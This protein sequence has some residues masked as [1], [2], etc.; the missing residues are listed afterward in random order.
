[1]E[2]LFNLL[3]N[4]LVIVLGLSFGSFLNVLIYRLPKEQSIVFPASYCPRCNKSIK[5][6]HNIPILSFILL[7]GKSNCCKT[8]ISLRYPLVEFISLS[9]WVWSFSNLELNNQ[10]IFL[11]MSS[12]LV[13]ILFTDYNEYYIPLELNIIMLL[14]CLIN[15]YI[16]DFSGFKYHVISLFLLSSYFFILMSVINYFLKKE[17]MG[18]GDIILI[19]VIGFWCGLIDSLII[20]FVASIF[21]IFHWFFLKV[22]S[23]NKDIILPFG[24]SLSLVTIILY[25]IK[26]TLQIDTNL[27]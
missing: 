3:Y 21:S 15:F 7:M 14:T 10:I 19:G 18:Y 2:V 12:C 23:K 24:Y 16:N 26:F 22:L 20:I 13:V 17:S 1:L 9:L 11:I 8:K 5:W 27:F 25:I 4:L 6:F